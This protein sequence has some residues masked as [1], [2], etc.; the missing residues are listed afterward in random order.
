MFPFRRNSE[1]SFR[2]LTFPSVCYDISQSNYMQGGCFQKIWSVLVQFV[3]WWS[4]ST[5]G[6]I[7]EVCLRDSVAFNYS[8]CRNAQM[9][10]AVDYSIEIRLLWEIGGIW[11][12]WGRER[13]EPVWPGMIFLDVS[14]QE[15]FWNFIFAFSHSLASSLLYANRILHGDCISGKFGAIQCWI[16][17]MVILEYDWPDCKGIFEWFSWI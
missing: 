4:W 11:S 16:C 1:I 5:I 6:L 8:H 13:I 17:K 9:L 10:F 7:A 2:I 3:K 14:L 15:K 12:K